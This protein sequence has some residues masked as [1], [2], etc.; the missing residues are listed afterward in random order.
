MRAVLFLLAAN[1][2]TNAKRAATAR[3]A[4]TVLLSAVSLGISTGAFLSWH[5]VHSSCLLPASVLEASLSI[6]H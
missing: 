1:T 5:T 2:V 6:T 4:A 3:A